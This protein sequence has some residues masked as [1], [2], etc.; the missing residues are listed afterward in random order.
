MWQDLLE[1]RRITVLELLKHPICWRLYS[2]AVFLM[3]LWHASLVGADGTINKL[4]KGP[5]ERSHKELIFVPFWDFE[6]CDTRCAVVK[7]DPPDFTV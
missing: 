2:V 1:G 6:L 5:T 3:S 7:A 4:L